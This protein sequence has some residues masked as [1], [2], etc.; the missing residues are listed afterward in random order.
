[1]A[2]VAKNG[3]DTIKL[4]T[5]DFSV[6][7]SITDLRNVGLLDNVRGGELLNYKKIKIDTTSKCRLYDLTIKPNINQLILECSI[8]KFL[9]QDN[10]ELADKKQLYDFM[11]AIDRELKENLILTDISSMRLKRLDMTNYAEMRFNTTE[12]FSR[13]LH[14]MNCRYIKKDMTKDFTHSMT[15]QNKSKGYCLYDKM[16]EIKK[17]DLIDSNIMRCEKRL[18][19]NHTIKNKYGIDT[20][21]E[22]YNN[23]DSIGLMA[24]DLIKN[25]IFN[26]ADTTQ[27]NNEVMLDLNDKIRVL[28]ELYSDKRNRNSNIIIMLFVLYG[29][30]ALKSGYDTSDIFERLC[31]ELIGSEINAEKRA[32][33]KYRLKQK[34]NSML[35][36]QTLYFERVEKKDTI[37]IYDLY[38]EIL[39]KLIA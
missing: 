38:E 10:Y 17:S 35:Q 26:Y 3:I 12:Y 19:N 27:L 1:M 11:S 28:K 22:L 36:T 30:E 8:P 31:S 39:H 14:K 6:K 15:W 7:G 9:Y 18:L 33:M 23:F 13:L 5:N 24:N 20:I 25:D 16:A 34:Y 32:I 21:T 2:E 4:Y 29:V 37:K